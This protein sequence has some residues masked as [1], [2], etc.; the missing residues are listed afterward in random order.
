MPETDGQLY[1]RFLTE[2]DEDAFDMLFDKHFEGL[3]FFLYGYVKNMDDAEELMMDTFAILS[4]GTARY[5]IRKDAEFK[6]WLYAIARNQACKFLHKRKETPFLPEHLELAVQ[7][8]EAGADEYSA[9]NASMESLSPESVILSNERRGKLWQALQSLKAEY[10]QVLY[11]T[12]FEDMETK[13]IARIMK[14][15]VKQVYNLTTRAKTALKEV[16]EGVDDA[17]D[18]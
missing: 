5:S 14:K 4:S 11:L 3:T 12:Y 1:I 7:G 18:I 17:W 13:E 8:K 16:L 6:T 2:G 10:G 15:T 9:E